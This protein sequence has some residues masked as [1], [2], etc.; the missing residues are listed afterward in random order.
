MHLQKV[1][2]ERKRSLR[3]LNKINIIFIWTHGNITL[4][5]YN[6]KKFKKR[7]FNP[8]LEYKPKILRVIFQ[9]G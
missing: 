3:G 8:K 5:E 7:E 2:D 6:P 9:K 4:L 1:Q